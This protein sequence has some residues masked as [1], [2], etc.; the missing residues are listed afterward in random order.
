MRCEQVRQT[1]LEETLEGNRPLS[2]W[3]ARHLERCADCRA[4]RE[5]L[6]AVDAALRAMPPERAPAGLAARV[7]ARAGPARPPEQ[8]FL[9][10][11]WGPALSLLLG[12]VWAYLAL[13]W[14]RGQALAGGLDPSW[15]GWPALLEQWLGE[16]QAGLGMVTL[17]LTAGIL[18]TLLGIG[19]GWFLGRERSP[20]AP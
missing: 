6:L 9:W 14:E 20:Q 1:I 12:L 13:L 18:C 5:R 8:P 16:H 7:L 10:T 17:S 11:L 15:T 19:L 4:F 3:P 2:G